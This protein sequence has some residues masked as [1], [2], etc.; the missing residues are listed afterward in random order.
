MKHYV[1]LQPAV[2]H[3]KRQTIWDRILDFFKI[4][5]DRG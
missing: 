1:Y 2:L 3:Y 5:E 4:E